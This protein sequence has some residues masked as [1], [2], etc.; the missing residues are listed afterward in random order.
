MK[1]YLATPYTHK[2]EEVMQARYQCVTKAAGVIM[3]QGHIVYS[4]ITHSHPIAKIHNLPREWSFW[5]KIDRAFIEWCDEL[6]V[7]WLSGWPESAGLKAEIEI[8]KELG[9]PIREYKCE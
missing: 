2:T 3:D 9:K 7:Y 4:P 1:I 6:W 5:E 8:A